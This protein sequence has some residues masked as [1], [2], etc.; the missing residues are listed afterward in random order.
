M[1]KSTDIDEGCNC[2]CHERF[3]ALM[4]IKCKIN[5]PERREVLMEKYRPI[6]AERRAVRKRVEL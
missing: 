5:H 2:F 4:C 6:E 1:K 3:G